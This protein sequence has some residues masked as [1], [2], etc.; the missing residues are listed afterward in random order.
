M[1]IEAAD[2][3]HAPLDGSL[4]TQLAQAS[5]VGQSSTLARCFASVGDQ[6]KREDGKR[7]TLVD[8]FR[9]SV[10]QTAASNK[11]S[12]SPE[13]SSTHQP[14]EPPN[15]LAL[16]YSTV[17]LLLAIGLG[18]GLISGVLL[19]KTLLASTGTDSSTS[20]KTLNNQAYLDYQIW[21]ATHDVNQSLLATFWRDEATREAPPPPAA[22]PSARSSCR[23]R[24][25][26]NIFKGIAN[27]YSYDV[28]SPFGNRETP[29]D[30]IEQDA[31]EQEGGK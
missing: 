6:T 25:A 17:G 11:R 7:S 23:S 3:G 1:D 19:C 8:Y 16:I 22:P 29:L 14:E 20:D 30:G 13:R 12:G 15:N 5:P 24:Q 31:A 10:V 9:R 2:D 26:Q 27:S 18:A 21:A 4:K 28:S